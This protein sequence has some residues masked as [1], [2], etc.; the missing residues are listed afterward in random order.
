MDGG[1][2]GLVGCGLLGSAIGERLLGAGLSVAAYDLSDEQAR[3]VR[4]AEFCRRIEQIGERA[5][6]IVF[7]LPDSTVVRAVLREL[8]PSLRP[9]TLIVDTTTGDPAETE[10]IAA[11]LATRGVGYVDATVGGSSA[12]TRRGE[13]IVMAGGS[14]DDVAA[15]RDILDAFAGRVFHVGP[16]GSGSRMKLVMNLVLGLNRA[17]LAEGLA[18][19]DACGLDGQAALDV[20]RASPAYSV[21]M[22]TKGRKMLTGDYQPEA[23]LAQHLKDVRLILEAA[24]DSGLP[25]PLSK[26]HRELLE[27][28]V[29]R[30]FGDQDNSV[31]RRAFGEVDE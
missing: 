31:V 17:V 22:D 24:S 23:R 20:L 29:E 30:G 25:L 21:V 11:E 9:G 14:G 18:F 10:R 12:Q 13:V 1:V 5:C 4:G 19:A 6:Q 15:A 28:V 2:I 27:G 8:N 26:L 7:C 3:G 16:C